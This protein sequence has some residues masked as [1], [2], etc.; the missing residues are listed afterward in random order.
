MSA[1]LLPSLMLLVGTVAQSQAGQT[2]PPPDCSAAVHRQFDF[3]IGD[4]DVRPNGS[5]PPAGQPPARNVITSA[6]AGCVILENWTTPQMSGQSINIYDRSRGQWHQT[7][8]DSTG[9]LHEYWGT[10]DGD[11]MVF[12]GS[13]PAPTN[14]AVRLHV[15]LTF[16]NLG[17]DRV[18]QFSERLNA[19]G[20]W[21]V[22]YD[23]MYTRRK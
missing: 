5:S 16:F 11:R 15:R 23:L 9:G 21:S 1:M 17:A 18:R 10:L 20:T 14:R 3:W 2:P 7:W 12:Y 4:W 19:D 13:M 22:N 8:A 6:Q